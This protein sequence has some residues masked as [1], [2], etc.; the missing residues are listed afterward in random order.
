MRKAPKCRNAKLFWLAFKVLECAETAM[1]GTLEGKN[2]LVT[3]GSR[4]IGRA[5]AIGLAAQ[6][7]NIA[8]GYLNN[9]ARAQEVVKTIVDEGGNAI[10]IKADLSRP[11]EVVRLFD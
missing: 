1:Q 11:A 2:A 6:G 9:D 7:V 4:G 5:I 3:G 10:A 8:I